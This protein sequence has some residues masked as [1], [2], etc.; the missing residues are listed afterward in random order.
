M[1]FPARLSP[2]A[3]NRPY[4]KYSTHISDTTRF[5]VAHAHSGDMKKSISFLLGVSLLLGS[6]TLG[7]AKSR[8]GSKSSSHKSAGKQKGS[9]KTR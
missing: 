2:R 3:C 4:Q 7:F 8:G 6:V 1:L 9:H 5:S